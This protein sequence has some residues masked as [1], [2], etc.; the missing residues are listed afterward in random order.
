MNKFI[1]KTFG[2]SSDQ[3][4]LMANLVHK[5]MACQCVRNVGGAAVSG[6]PTQSMGAGV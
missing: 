5:S 1:F 3:G 4:K 6:A 2:C